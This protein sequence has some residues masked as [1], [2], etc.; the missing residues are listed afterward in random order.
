MEA[1]SRMYQDLLLDYPRAAF[2]A[3]KHGDQPLRLAEC[4]WKMGGKEITVEILAEFD[5]D[6]TRHG[7]IIKLWAEMGE[8]KKALDMAEDKAAY[9]EPDSAY[10]AAGDACRLAGQNKEAMA[11]YQEV[12]A[13]P[14][15][16][17]DVKKNKQ[18]AQASVQAIKLFDS[19][20]LGRIPDGTYLGSSIAYAG[21]LEVAVTIKSGRIE[22]VKVTKHK[23]KQF[24]SSITETTGQIIA[25]QSIKGI[26]MTSGATITS[27]AIINATAKAL[28][29]K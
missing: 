2:W 13:I 23:E 21:M 11:Y 19:L 16:K 17:G 14:G 18:R 1:L 22:D 4:Y 26:Q 12:L 7:S 10:L 28:A 20:D 29:G 27:E 6:T 24:Y 25:K 8:L 15:E 5:E 9:G 3:R